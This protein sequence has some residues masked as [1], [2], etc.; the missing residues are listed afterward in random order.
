MGTSSERVGESDSKNDQGAFDDS[1]SQFDYV[2]ADGYRRSREPINRRFAHF[3]S[4]A[5]LVGEA[6]KEV[7]GIGVAPHPMP[8]LR[9]GGES[10]ETAKIP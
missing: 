9:H 4:W 1:G 8:W 10:G 2:L 5:K 3:S 6:E 7:T